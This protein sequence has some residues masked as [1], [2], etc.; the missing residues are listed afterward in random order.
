LLPIEE[1][2]SIDPALFEYWEADMNT[3]NAPVCTMTPAM[4]P[5]A[6]DPYTP[7]D[8]QSMTKALID[9]L[10]SPAERYKMMAEAAYFQAE[11]RGFKPGHEL[12]DWLWA[13]HEVNEACGLVERWPRWDLAND[14]SLPAN[15]CPPWLD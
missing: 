10:F 6:V 14:E 8:C 2:C 1:P 13:E 3:V 5:C 7:A 9:Q 12:E 4:P 11:R 15:A